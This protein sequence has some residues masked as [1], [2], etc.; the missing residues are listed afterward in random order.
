MSQPRDAFE[1]MLAAQSLSENLPLVT[2]DPV[3]SE[4]GVET[5]RSWA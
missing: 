5:L 4:L 2:G 3:S 1:R